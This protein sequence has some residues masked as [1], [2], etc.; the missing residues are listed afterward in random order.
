MPRRKKILTPE[1]SKALELI[2]EATPTKK[3]T[4][5]NLSKIQRSVLFRHAE[6]ILEEAF[7]ATRKQIRQ[8]NLAAAKLGFEINGMIRGAGIH[9]STNIQ[10]NNQQVSDVGGRSLESLVRQLDARE[11]QQSKASDFVEL[12]PY[13]E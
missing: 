12:T 6:A 10:N 5:R 11:L 7:Q 1:E 2:Q 8:G 9:V 3:A 13:D 4:Q